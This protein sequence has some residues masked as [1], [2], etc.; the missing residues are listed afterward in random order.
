MTTR[1]RK[2]TS[3]PVPLGLGATFSVRLMLDQERWVRK[4][5]RR[6]KVS[7]AAALRALLLEHGLPGKAVEK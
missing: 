4:E 2:Q 3:G 5:A 6:R 7:V 1:R